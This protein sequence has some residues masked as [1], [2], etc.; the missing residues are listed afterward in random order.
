MDQETQ[1]KLDKLEKMEKAGRERARKY[2]EKVREGGRMQIS[3][4]I[5]KEAYNEI[6]RRRDAALLQGA[7]A[8]T[9]TVIESLLFPNV[10]ANVSID[11]KPAPK[12]PEYSLFDD[13]E[14]KATDT[15]AQKPMP[16]V[17]P[18]KPEE[19]EYDPWGMPIELP[20]YHGKT[21][22][23]EDRD[24]VVIKVGHNVGIRRFG[25][26]CWFRLWCWCCLWCKSRLIPIIHWLADKI[27]YFFTFNHSKLD[28]VI[29]Q[30]QLS[31]V[32]INGLG[33]WCWCNGSIEQGPLYNLR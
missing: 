8:T 18:Q 9:G 16:E 2:I 30:A 29:K 26:G 27:K 11:I 3:A 31:R 25:N 23:V 20:T 1:D 19:I 21:I 28:G 22:S 14:P 32:V 12:E 7:K 10:N 13:L 17:K 33:C 24:K 15:P 4:I 5:S 6:C